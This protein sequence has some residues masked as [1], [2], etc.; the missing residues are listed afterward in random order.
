MGVYEY[1][2]KRGK[3]INVS[4]DLEGTKVKAY[5]M[6]FLFKLSWSMP[7]SGDADQADRIVNRIVNAWEDANE[8]PEYFV[9]CPSLDNKPREGNQVRKLADHERSRLFWTDTN[10]I[11]G[12]CVGMLKKVGNQWTVVQHFVNP[13]PTTVWDNDAEEWVP[14][15]MVY[16]VQ[17]GEIVEVGREPIEN[18]E[19][20]LA[21]R[22]A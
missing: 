22:T 17:D 9:V 3:P 5:R 10:K 14:V 12:E 13:S 6:E 15:R 2:I 20:Y 21:E 16:E 8:L 11:Q 1:G 18:P 19:Q 7:L 4:I